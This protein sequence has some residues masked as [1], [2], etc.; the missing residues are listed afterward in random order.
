MTPAVSVV[1]ATHNY[2][3]FLGNALDSALGQTFDDFE[4]IVVDDGSTDNT[5]SVVLPYLR[6]ERIRYERTERR[7]QPRAKNLGIQLARAPLIAFLDADDVWLPTKLDR[8]VAVFREDPE[9]GVVYTRRLLIDE[10]GWELEYAQPPLY[11]GWVLPRI[12]RHNFI[13]FSSSVVRRRVFEEVGAF[14]EELALSIDYE[15]WLRVARHYRFDYVNQPLVLY[16]TG[17]DSLSRRKRERVHT[18]NAIIHRFLDEYG[19]RAVLPPALVRLSLAELYC[20]MGGAV[21]GSERAYWFSRALWQR[22]QHAQAW[23]ALLAFW[24]PGRIRSLV[25]RALGKPDWERPRRVIPTLGPSTIPLPVSPSNDADVSPDLAIASVGVHLMP[26]LPDGEDLLEPSNSTTSRRALIA[27]AAASWLGFA[28]QVVA[29]FFLSPILIHGLGDSRYGIWAL[30][31]SVLAYLMLFDLGVAAAVVR[32]VARYEAARNRKELNRVFNTSVF[33]FAIAGS[34]ALVVGL[35]IALGGMGILGVPPELQDEARITIIL[36][37]L[38][39]ALGLPLGVFPAVLD[40]LGRYP[41]KTVVRTAGLIARI[42]LFMLIIHSGGGLI[43]M[44]WMITAT[45]VVEHIALAVAAYRY[46]PELRFAPRYVDRHTFRRIRGYSVNAL[47]A[48]LAGRISFQTDSLVIS[49]F[50]Y[51]QFITFFAVGARLVEYVKSSMRAITTVLTPAVST[52]EA[53]GNHAAIRR[54]LVNGTRFVLWTTLPIQAG[55]ILL[56]KPFLA[57]WLQ[58]RYA[59]ACYPVLVILALPLALALSQSVAGRI[60]Y[61]IGR[62]RWYARLTIMEAGA[63]LILSLVLVTPFGIEGVAWGTTIPNVVFNL[64]LAVYACRLLKVNVTSYLRR[65]FLEPLAVT[66][67]LTLIWLGATRER[68]PQTW[69]ELVLVTTSGALGYVVMAALVELGPRALLRYVKTLPSR[70]TTFFYLRPAA[71]HR[72]HVPCVSLVPKESLGTRGNA[73]ITT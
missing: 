58:P 21:E 16:R 35:G 37:S 20:D 36:L 12:F 43:E 55:L 1:I 52:L 24:W 49:A 61:G 5:P 3:R 17:H 15:L 34:A 23:H 2:G 27:N 28:A 7:G 50:L 57:L 33:I 71:V 32:F 54:M 48:M 44:A 9:V 8:Q 51:P 18:A 67:L 4:A 29:T 73:R 59:D 6:D 14:D 65:S 11:R 56:G 26:E 30:V 68:M 10:D 63:N 62:L 13:C 22:P 66:S 69:M 70:S 25:R 40:G 72:D 64:I 39:L 45:N 41:A 46:L 31:D 53:K 19:G 38:N 47:L 60:L 42:P